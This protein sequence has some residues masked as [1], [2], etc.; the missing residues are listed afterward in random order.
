MDFTF[1]SLFY[2]EGEHLAGVDESGVVD[3]AGP[4]VA[5]CVIFPRKYNQSDF[6]KLFAVDDCKVVPEKIRVE[7]LSIILDSVKAFG[8]GAVSAREIDM[9]GPVKASTVAMVRSIKACAL[10]SNKTHL[11]PDFI[12]IDGD[13]YLKIKYPQV[14]VID[15]DRKSLHVAAASIIA[16]SYRDSIM[17]DYDKSYPGY[18]W[19]KNKGHACAN[20]FSG[21]DKYGIVEGIHRVKSWPFIGRSKED[22]NTPKGAVKWSKRREEWK[23]V[24]EKRMIQSL[25]QNLWSSKPP[26]SNHS[27]N[28][29]NQLKREGKLGKDM[30][31]T[32]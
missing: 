26:L 28:S 3:I 23:K 16:K 32:D 1:D 7:L 10:V 12:I 18:D 2:N 9:I 8:I 4:I 25:D 19:A 22:K 11:S 30:K 20:H 29:R 21:I 6:T 31:N 15:A 27:M 17:V 5:A 14:T 13:R 24:T